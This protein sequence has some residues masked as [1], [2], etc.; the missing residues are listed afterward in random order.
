MP[1]IQQ[2]LTPEVLRSIDASTFNATYQALGTPLDNPSRIMKIT[3][4]SDVDVLVSWD[5]VEDHEFVPMGSFLLLDET[6]NAVPQSQ[7]AAPQGTQIYVNG[8]AGTGS[9]YL[10]TYYAS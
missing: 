9:V 6:A 5:G 7:L 4:A 3:N 10:S 8:S 2:R 1:A